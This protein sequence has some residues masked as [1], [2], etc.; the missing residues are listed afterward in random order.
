MN[1]KE[2]RRISKF[3]S[4]VLRHQPDAIGISL[5]SAGWVGVDDLIRAAREHGTAITP[6]EL[7]HVVSTNDKRRFAFSEDGLRIRAQQ[8]HSVIVEYDYSPIEPPAVLYHGT[9]TRVLDTILAEGLRA[10]SR[11]HVHLSS[12]FETAIKVGQRHGK[13]VVLLVDA[14]AMHNAAFKFFKTPNDVWLVERVPPSFLR[15]ADKD[16][17]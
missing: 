1:E 7:S 12:H 13:P 10:M 3:L 8:G 16:D 2:A 17:L 9:A 15:V 5:D 6:A 11:T 4:L 14:A